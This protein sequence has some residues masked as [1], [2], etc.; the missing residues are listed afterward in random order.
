MPSGKYIVAVCCLCLKLGN[1]GCRKS[2]FDVMLLSKYFPGGI[3]I[4]LLRILTGKTHPQN[5]TQTLK[6]N[7]NIEI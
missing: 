3:F 1:K 5:K 2:S 6:K 4:Y 7:M